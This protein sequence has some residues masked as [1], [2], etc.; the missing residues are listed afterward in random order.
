MKPKELK[1]GDK[2]MFVNGNVL[3]D[4]IENTI[5]NGNK[6][7]EKKVEESLPNYIVPAS[8]FDGAYIVGVPC[9]V[10]SKKPY[11]QKRK[12][13]FGESLEDVID[14]VSLLSG[15]KYTIPNSWYVG[16]DS[17]IDA[18][19]NSKINLNLL[20]KNVN[21]LIGRKYYPKDNSYI[22]DSNGDYHPLVG[23]ECTVASIPFK[24]V[25][26]PCGKKI[27]RPFILVEYNGEIYRTLFGEWNFYPRPIK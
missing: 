20:N 27:I 21:S 4:I 16:Y 23:K 12:H 6:K 14:V 15:I 8:N 26:T 18:V 17:V 2:L 24:D 10:I 25:V 3:T 1:V 5:K 11:K 7:A 22:S 9:E 13:V 19:K